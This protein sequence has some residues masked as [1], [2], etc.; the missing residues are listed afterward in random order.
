MAISAKLECN[1]E[2]CPAFLVLVATPPGIM[3]SALRTF[4]GTMAG[5][6]VVAYAAACQIELLTLLEG[7]RPNLLLFD[8]DLAVYKSDGYARPLPDLFRQLHCAYPEMPIILLANDLK[9]KNLALEAG[10]HEV[11][12][13]GALDVRLRQAILRLI[14][15]YAE[16]E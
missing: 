2:E 12:L 1:M 3:S 4:L 7:I 6:K 9:Q 14:P 5:V 16:T 13:K 8:A 15:P 10:V 11:I